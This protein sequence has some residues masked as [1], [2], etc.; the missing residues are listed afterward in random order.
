[1]NFLNLFRRKL[2]KET[3]LQD[4]RIEVEG[5]KANATQEEISKLNIEYFDADSKFGCIYGQMTGTC[6]SARA[7]ELMD[8]SCVR[9]TKFSD[10]VDDKTFDVVAKK[11]NGKYTSQTWEKTW[12][13]GIYSRNFNHLSMIELYI[14]LKGASPKNI[15]DYLKGEVETL[16]LPLD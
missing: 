12:G 11:I 5:L 6:S 9:V 3:F 13:N 4:V 14:F 10:N 16:E 8:K 7:K 1:M 2:T 15:M